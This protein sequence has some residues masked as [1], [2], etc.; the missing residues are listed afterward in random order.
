MPKFAELKLE[1]LM[2]LDDGRVAITFKEAL[3]QIVSDCTDRPGDKSPRIVSLN[4]QIVPIV[5][6]QTGQCDLVN[7]E[8]KIVCKV[9]DRR[10]KTYQFG[11][12]KSSN[13]AML[14]FNQ[15]SPQSVNQQTVFDGEDDDDK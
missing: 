8:F 9:P 15:H 3:K 2:N 7:G 5:D 12:R 4:L 14:V 1:D 10:S 11:V 13:G 6:V